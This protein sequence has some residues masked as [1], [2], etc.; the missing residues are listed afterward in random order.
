MI[1]SAVSDG[2]PSEVLALRDLAESEWRN[3]NLLTRDRAHRGRS[4]QKGCWEVFNEMSA[5][6]LGCLITD[7]RSLCRMLDTSPKYSKMFVDAQR[8]GLAKPFI[9]E[10]NNFSFAL[11]RFDS[12]SVPLW[13][14]IS[15]LP[16]VYRFLASLTLEGDAV[17]QRW[18]TALICRLTGPTAYRSII[19]AALAADAVL[20]G[21]KMIRWDDVAESNAILKGSEASLIKSVD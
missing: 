11:Q 5:G 4:I 8:R 20:V 2:G 12:L 10:I 7:E 14:V 18:A 19:G 13:K 9:R 3:C 21:H 1:T 16:A 17:D 15:M 6:L